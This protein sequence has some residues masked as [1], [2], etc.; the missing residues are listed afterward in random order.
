MEYMEISLSCEDRN[1]L[2]QICVKLFWWSSFPWKPSRIE[3]FLTRF[4]QQRAGVSTFN[5]R[6][7]A[8]EDA[9]SS[10]H[11]CFLEYAKAL[12]I[13]VLKR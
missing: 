11:T 8:E 3:Q 12:R 7:G 13:I 5:E 4:L 6:R 10:L 1:A 9:S 2:C